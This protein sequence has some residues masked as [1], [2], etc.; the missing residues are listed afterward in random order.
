MSKFTAILGAAILAISVSGTISTTAHADEAKLI[1]KGS[2]VFKKC[3]AC[4]V[5]DEAKNKAGPHLLNIVGRKAG[6]AEGYS[7]SDAVKAKA[8]EGLVW[9]EANLA[10]FLEKPRKFLKGTK[11]AFGGLR[12]EKDRNAI[13]AYF[14]SLASA[15]EEA[16]KEEAK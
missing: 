3:K 8:A 12:K 15:K 9:D 16:P 2:K 5:V 1:K 11:M 6:A 14:K 10:A 7:Y 4:H 13:I